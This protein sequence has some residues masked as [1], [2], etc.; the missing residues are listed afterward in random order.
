M[1][2]PVQHFEPLSLGQ[3]SPMAYALSQ[4]PSVVN[5]SMQQY[6]QMQQDKIQRALYDQRMQEEAIKMKYLESGLKADLAS[7]QAEINK[8]NAMANLPL[9]GLQLPGVAGQSMAIETLGQVFG[10]NSPQY[11]R[12]KQAFDLDQ[13]SQ[14]QN[15][16]YQAA[17]TKS[18][19]ERYLTP[20]GRGYLEEARVNQGQ[21]PTGQSWGEVLG[22]TSNSKDQ[23]FTPEEMKQNYEMIRLKA[24]TDP[25]A[26]QKNLYARNIDK[27]LQSFKP[28]DLTK[29]S[30]IIGSIQRGLNAGLAPTGHETK[31]YDKYNEA[32]SAID[33][34]ASQVRQ[35]YGD[36]VQANSMDRIADMFK[37][38]S[39]KSNPKLALETLNNNISNLKNEMGTYQSALQGTDIYKGNDN[40]SKV[41]KNVDNDPLGIR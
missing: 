2:T 21:S 20:G 28:E 27:T 36:S 26:R 9:S 32:L 5:Q 29:Y 19:P 37:T 7:K 35:F 11:L 39:W 16:I 25:T 12:A 8:A 40:K 24:S 23:P 31:N 34:L 14:N 1:P 30:G 41:S 18:M 15:M 13:Q 22:T 33:L 4:L 3:V 6:Q 10:K 17:L 38:G